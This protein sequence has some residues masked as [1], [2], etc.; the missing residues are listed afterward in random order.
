MLWVPPHI[1]T[2][3]NESRHER[4]CGPLKLFQIVQPDDTPLDPPLPQKKRREHD[5]EERDKELQWLNAERASLGL[6]AIDS[7]WLSSLVKFDYGRN[8]EGCWRAHHVVAHLEEFIGILEH[9][10]PAF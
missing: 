7:T 10:A 8:R 9:V 5:D 6:P 2:E 1:F 3:I 4:G